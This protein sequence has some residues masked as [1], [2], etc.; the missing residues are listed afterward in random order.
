[1]T[2]KEFLSQGLV[3]QKKLEEKAIR[4]ERLQ[5]RAEK[6]TVSFGDGTATISDGNSREKLLAEIV[7]LKDE[8]E[9]NVKELHAKKEEILKIVDLVS[10]KNWR[11]VLEYR[12]VWL[13]GFEEIATTLYYSKVNIFV[14]HKKA[15]ENVNEIAKD[16]SKFD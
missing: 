3:L 9:K 6:I 14:L 7:D 15:I 5:S 10:N 4:L 2:A 1:M 11:L 13:M 16:Y 8:I 12:Y